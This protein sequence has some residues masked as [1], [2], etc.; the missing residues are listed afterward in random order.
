MNIEELQAFRAQEDAEELARLKEQYKGWWQHKKV[1]TINA[2]PADILRAVD[3]YAKREHPEFPQDPAVAP[4]GD[5]GV[6]SGATISQWHRTNDITAADGYV[7]HCVPF[8]EWQPGPFTVSTVH[9]EAC[10]VTATPTRTR[11]ELSL[12]K[13]PHLGRWYERLQEFILEN[14]PEAGAWRRVHPATAGSTSSTT[15]PEPPSGERATVATQPAGA[16]EVVKEKPAW[17]PRRA[18]T[19]AQWSRAYGIISDMRDEATDPG[20]WQSDSLPALEDYRERLG[21][22]MNWKPSTK[23]VGR[24]LQ[25][26]ESEWLK[27]TKKTKRQ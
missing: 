24:I 15:P 12:E 22:E 1:Y 9:I 6:D 16:A 8:V 17:F 4:L 10:A 20:N 2:T 11:V 13:G 25:A 7:W 27:K 3:F 19:L 5:L 14:Y 18:T 23:T 26:G 21:Q